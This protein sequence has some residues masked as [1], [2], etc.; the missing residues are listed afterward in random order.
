MLGRCCG[1]SVSQFFSQQTC[2][3]S[4]SP[5]SS[6]PHGGYP[7]IGMTYWLDGKTFQDDHNLYLMSDAHLLTDAF[8]AFPFRKMGMEYYGLDP[9]KYVILPQYA[10]DYLYKYTGRE[11]EL[12]TDID[13]YLWIEKSIRGGISII[14]M[15]NFDPNVS[16]SWLIYV[17]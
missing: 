15:K 5:T 2:H 3:I 8:E 11:Q 14:C 6:F 17:C 13:M 16:L 12:F 9:S 1:Q 7:Y 4:V 10:N